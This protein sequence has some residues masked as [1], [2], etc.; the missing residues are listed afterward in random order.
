MRLT[1]LLAEKKNTCQ[2]S[3]LA[4]GVILRQVFS[5]LISPQQVTG[6]YDG[7]FPLELLSS[8]SELFHEFA[9]TFLTIFSSISV[10]FFL[11]VRYVVN[12]CRERNCE[13]NVGTFRRDFGN[14]LFRNRLSHPA[15]KA[16]TITSPSWYNLTTNQFAHEQSISQ[17]AMISVNSVKAIFLPQQDQ[18]SR[19]RRFRKT[20]S[21]RV[22]N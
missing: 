5:I 13:R 3:A 19:T 14:R 16:L 1:K 10:D 4:T 2:S 6:N 20:L 15:S 12:K 18:V 11:C 17:L 9:F 22:R 8:I 21:A 7:S